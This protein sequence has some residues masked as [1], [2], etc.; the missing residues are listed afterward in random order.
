V[1]TTETPVSCPPSAAEPC[2]CHKSFASVVP[3]HRGHCCF[4]PATQACHPAEVAEW[5]QQSALRHPSREGT[6]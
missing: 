1:T 4:F 3:S 6:R 2:Q 5:E